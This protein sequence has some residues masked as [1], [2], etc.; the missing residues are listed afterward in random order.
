M[1]P[2]RRY[3]VT[4][5]ILSFPFLFARKFS[6][7]RTHFAAVSTKCR[8]QVILSACAYELP[9]PPLHSAHPPLVAR[10]VVTPIRLSNQGVYLTVTLFASS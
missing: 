2:Y 7:M 4:M 5:E 1:P 3:S 10:D 8:K 6:S 9:P